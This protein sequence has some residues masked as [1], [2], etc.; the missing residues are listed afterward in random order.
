MLE[1]NDERKPNSVNVNTHKIFKLNQT[2]NSNYEAK[3]DVLLS[4]S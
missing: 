4:Y 3:R 1:L 2:P